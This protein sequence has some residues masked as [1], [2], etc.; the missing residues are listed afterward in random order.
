MSRLS[1]RTILGLAVA[2]ALAPFA[3]AQPFAP[4]IGYVYP[5][6]GRQG[7]EFQV[8]VGG[9]ALDGI[10]QAHVSGRGVQAKLVE[11][12]KPVTQQQFNQLRE[13]LQELQ[14][15]TKTAETYKEIAEIRKKL[16]TF[17]RRPTN[18]AI[19]ETVTLQITVAPDAALGP[20]ELRLGT[21]NGL[22]NPL[23]FCVDQLP[24]FSRKT[25]KNLDLP[26]FGQGARF[27]NDAP[28]TTSAAPLEIS[29]PA[30]VNG[31]IMPGTVDRYRFHAS[32]GQRLV[33]AAKARELIPYLPDAVP[34]WFQATLALSDAEG[35]E[36]AYD[37]DYRFHPDPV[38]LVEIPKD[39][40]YVVE[41]KDAVYRGREDFVYRIELGELPFI[42]S[43]FPLGGP[44][45]AKHTV[46]LTG[47]NL[48][49]KKIT[50]DDS[51]QVAGIYPLGVS[52]NGRTS[53]QLPFAVDTLPEQQEQEPNNKP[54]QAQRV[55]LPVIVNGRIDQP[56]DWDVFS[57]NGRAGDEIVAE[58]Y[59]RRLDSPL[60][61]VLKLTDATGQQLAFNDDHE[62]KGSGLLTHH[63]DSWLRA[64]LPA[65]GTYFVHISDA[66]HH[67]GAE[68]AYRL[69][70]S[71]PRPDF[72]LRL[73]PSSISV[74]GGGCVPLTVYALR[75][76]GFSGEISLTLQNA[77]AG[78][79]LSG[80]KIPANQNQVR[81]TLA[82]PISAS[83]EPISLSLVG[84]ATIQGQEVTRSAAPADD[85]MQ[86]F[87]YRHLVPAQEL[88]VAV[89]GRSM[90]RA[91]GGMA[92][93]AP[94]KIPAGGTVSVRLAV[95][96]STFAAR[97]NLELNEPPEGISIKDVSSAGFGTEL[98][99]QCDAAKVKPGLAGNLIVSVF[100]QAKQAA[101][102][103]RSRI[104]VTTLPAIPF[105]VVDGKPS[106]AAPAS[107]K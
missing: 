46:E 79:I 98:V 5:A 23:A 54:E 87:A 100:A 61:S 45:G 77:P 55:S 3:Q 22:T 7:A 82:A 29:L 6:G 51:S 105:Q 88:Q 71:A 17:V 92:G 64:K 43:I 47:W 66:Q 96:T 16:A 35:N 2:G 84:R 69:R 25:A 38:L 78:F 103:N 95:P 20:R 37:D 97:I 80:G 102:P 65:D 28:R 52:R 11:Y 24:E 56:D 40:E 50:R 91:A 74:R 10:A 33:I 86:A 73:V 57:F 75:K 93:A 42:T 9:Q 49:E 106:D 8:T 44:A 68:Y 15:G 62:D 59:A 12:V 36:V 90:G 18:P 53:N 21:P 4:H 30:I 14:Q 81:V 41:I 76:D 101:K 58:V 70:I 104:P 63:A 94:V 13:R 72:A 27:R 1:W 67:G 89:S 39:G 19:A 83:S 107:T 31:Q 32:R 34:G 26:A 85:M 99:L 60:D 48:P